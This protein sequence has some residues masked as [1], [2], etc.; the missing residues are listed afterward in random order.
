MLAVELA[1]GAIQSNKALDLRRRKIAR[2][3]HNTSTALRIES[4]EMLGPSVVAGR[5]SSQGNLPL[6]APARVLARPDSLAVDA[7]A[8]EVFIE[9]LREGLLQPLDVARRI[10]HSSSLTLG[11]AGENRRAAAATLW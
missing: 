10:N 11:A 7:C 4:E 5:E 6:H 2:P 8:H 9:D 1:A 3:E